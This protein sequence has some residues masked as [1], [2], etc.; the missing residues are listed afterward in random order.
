MSDERIVCGAL[1]TW[2]ESIHEAATTDARLP[3]CPHCG[4]PL[5]E[6]ADY[7]KWIDGAEKVSHEYAISYVEALFWV[8]DKCNRA[9]GVNLNDLPPGFTPPIWRWFVQETQND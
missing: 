5:F 8:R 6:V 7:G 2:W 1:C 9:L 4:G 3:C